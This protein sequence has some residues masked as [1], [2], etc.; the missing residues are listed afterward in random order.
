LVA[1]VVWALT[2]WGPLLL[3]NLILAR[4][5]MFLYFYPYWEARAAALSAGRLPLWAP[6]IFMGA[7]FLAN[8]QTGSLYPFNWL[9][10]GLAAPDA[11]KASLALHAL[12]A[13]LG[14]WLFARRRLG[15]PV[16][17]AMAVS[18]LFGL[19]GYL[20]AQAEHINQFQALSWFPWLLWRLPPPERLKDR[21]AILWC[22]LVV[23]LQLLAGHTQSVFISLSG[24]GVWLLVERLQQPASGPVWRRLFAAGVQVGVVMA[25]LMLAGVA[26]AA[27]QLVPTL[28]LSQQS[29]RSGGLP[30]S[31]A[32][33]FSLDPWLLGL[34]L[35]P[36]Y[37]NG[38]FTEFVASIGLIGLGLAVLGAWSSRRPA[39]FPALV[40]TLTGLTFAL[41]AFSPVYLGLSLVPPFNLFRVPA[42]F[43]FLMAFG[44]AVLA[45]LGLDVLRR[46][47]LSRRASWAALA[48]PGL[49]A[50]ASLLSVGVTPAGETGPRA[51]PALADL[52][53]WAMALATWAALVWGASRLPGAGRA[54]AALAVC[55]VELALAARTLP[56]QLLT[57]PEAYASLR[58]AAATLVAG[59]HGQ[60][61][62]ERFVS[63]S[64]LQFDPGDLG[65]LRPM[66]SRELSPAGLDLLIIA[67]KHQEVFSPN[68]SLT[69][70]VQA[71]DGFDGGVLPL[72]S[73][74]TFTSLFMAGSP[75]ADGRLR[76][77]VTVTPDQRLLALAGVRWLIA[78][79]T[80][81]VW[82]GGVYYDR[83][84]ALDLAAGERA[85]FDVWPSYPA[86]HL[87]L[88]GAAGADATITFV[89][90][91]GGRHIRPARDYLITADTRPAGR[92][93]NTPVRIEFQG[94]LLL[95]SASLTEEESGSFQT[96][97]L[98]PFHLVHS[99]DV[100]VY[101]TTATPARAFVAADVIIAD[102]HEALQRLADPAFDPART[103]LVSPGQAPATSAIG[104]SQPVT[105]TAY[106]PE[107]VT[108]RASGP[109]V[110]VLADA[111]YPGWEATVSG[112]S[113]PVLRANIM[114]RA[115]VLPPGEH[116]VQFT[117]VPRS[118]ALGLLLSAI[119]AV[120]WLT[121][122]AD[123]WLVRLLP[124]LVRANQREAANQEGESQ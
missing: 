71:V 57:A 24:A 48:V 120:V 102:D 65:E 54:G 84:F 28:E 19:G 61:V 115:V 5:D 69:W 13:L 35:M 1:V 106:Q 32:L 94:P 25:A 77:R 74:A 41:G 38:L 34:A 88:I 56:I 93:P 15:L 72:R 39:R 91:A 123:W 96:L 124:S 20:L 2:V 118:L 55:A 85:G 44:M 31:E 73:Y 18:G 11:V 90:A 16:L 98:A 29:L 70:G 101:A 75:S 64:A 81:D 104:L 113:V 68:L 119:A 40:L 51:W 79:K 87:G 46:G 47:A 110:L 121:L 8:P 111:Y 63:M 33:S 105:I 109:G 82:R 22:G 99:G 21:L 7:P 116:E 78:D 23:A 117:Y 52:A 80:S 108:L 50:L 53:G 95:D 67:S 89:D 9:V 49:A 114:F 45:G 107:Q 12:V 122:S 3:T 76:E 92:A 66:W 14:A 86:T 6:E 36:A 83:Q 112:Q 97:T 62:P 27:A 59:A 17:S 42:R 100:K 103:V 30:W 60:P 43:L 37:S 58:P 4:G 10:N 26:L